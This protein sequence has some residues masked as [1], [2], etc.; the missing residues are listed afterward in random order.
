MLSALRQAQVEGL[1]VTVAVAGSLDEEPHDVYLL[2]L[3]PPHGSEA[4]DRF[5]EVPYLEGLEPVLEA[6][7]GPPSWAVDISRTHRSDRGGVGEAYL[8]VHLVTGT[9]PGSFGSDPDLTPVVQA[10]LTQMADGPARGTAADPLSHDDA[11]EAGVAA[12]TQAFPNV[13]PESLSLTDEENHAAQGQ[14]SLGL[15]LAGV[16]RFQVQLGLVPG[17]PESA[18]VRRLPVSEVVDSVGL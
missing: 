3:T 18:H 5:D 10:A 16:A 17:V 8:A 11:L 7:G 14:W 6:V 2:D 1:R 4:G 9:A 12:V 13:D 15:V